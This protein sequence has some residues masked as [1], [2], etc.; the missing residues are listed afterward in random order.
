VQRH[1]TGRGPRGCGPPALRSAT[2]VESRTTCCRPV[3]LPSL[4]RRRQRRTDAGSCRDTA[5]EQCVWTRAQV[6]GAW[7]QHAERRAGHR[8]AQGGAPAQPTKSSP[9]Y[10]GPGYHPA[11]DP[12]ATQ[13]RAFEAC[14]CGPSTMA[15]NCAGTPRSSRRPLHPSAALPLWQDSS[16]T[17]IHSDDGHACRRL[18]TR[19]VC[20]MSPPIHMAIRHQLSANPW[21]PTADCSLWTRAATGRKAR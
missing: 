4:R 19:T 5:A 12:Y 2:A 17:T 20:A 3:V 8:H 21:S 10:H 6:S 15:W 7:P 1:H 9:V 16:R 14:D 18:E 13:G 11:R